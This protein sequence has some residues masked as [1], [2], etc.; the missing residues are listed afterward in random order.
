MI[1][2]YEHIKT[3]CPR[4]CYDGCGMIV[5]K[6]NGAI[7]RVYG[8][9]KHPISRGTL[10]GKCAIAYN[11]VFQ[12][13]QARLLYPQKRVGVKGEGRFERISWGE[14]IETIASKLGSIVKSH[15]S[16]AILN[17][18]YTGTLS[19][20]ASYYP[21]R[22]FNRLGATEVLPDTICNMAGQV[23]WEI[24]FGN[25]CVGFDPR[26]AKDSSCILVWGAN[27]ANSGP[28]AHKHWLPESPAKIIVVDP[29]CTQTA[30]EADL[31]L[32]PIPGT[33]AALAFSLLH[34]L[35]RDGF[36]DT[37]FI[38]NN[39]IGLDELLPTL[40]ECTP[41][42]GE[43]KTGIPASLIEQAAHLYG[44]GPSLLWAGQ[45]LQRQKTGGNVMRACGLLPALTGNVGKPGAGFYYLNE[46]P[47]IAGAD[48]ES[49]LGEKLSKDGQPGISHM[50][51][52]EQLEDVDKSQALVCWNTNPAASVPQQQRF[53]HA[54]KREDLF[55]VVIDCFSTDTTDFAD[56]LLPAASFLEFDDLT[57]SYFHLNIGAQ[58]KA[59]EPMGESLPNQEIFRR[60]S[61]EMNF[62]EPEL[63]EA[64]SVVLSRL[65]TEMQ[66]DLDFDA[67]KQKGWHS[68]SE[69]ILLFHED[70]KFDTPSGKIEIASEKA[71]NMGLPR[72]PQ[73]W[74][75]EPPQSDRVRLI[76]P[77]SRWRMNDSYANDKTIHKVSR[78]ATV[79]LHP[80]DAN[81][82]GV[83]EG[84][85]V[86]LE[87]ETG[88]IE[89]TLQIDDIVQKGVALSYKGR[90]PKQEHMCRNLNTVN[91]GLKS[92]MGESSSVHSIE[93]SI[94]PC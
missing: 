78:D 66:T 20:L 79:I 84:A 4:D 77:S 16:Q 5:E 52:A 32:Q 44:S 81:R 88:W 6:E 24:L 3:T 65:L 13:E 85:R 9:P 61:K 10:C 86:R 25:P 43:V 38:N 75:D 45:A 35:Q 60:L 1:D 68:I 51:F 26:T 54:L 55:T 67:L 8:D 28:H 87:N 82:F 71:E 23:A 57:Y 50:D 46:T 94:R 76:S 41:S 7:R 89:L 56:I 53:H 36:F 47:I 69:S 11:G 2:K 34:V 80:E 37:D 15:G 62:V 42:W 14:A 59:C 18:H 74:A 72:L 39:T 48:F 40:Q 90:W 58:T 70:Y 49:L 91:P 93:V 83:K 73:P 27:P 22:F 12:D 30:K 64:D 29:I 63:F 17:T 92:D 19:L 31:H 21:M 33:D